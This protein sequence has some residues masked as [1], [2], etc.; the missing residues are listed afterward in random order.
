METSFQQPEENNPHFIVKR[1]VESTGELVIKEEMIDEIKDDYNHE[2]FKEEMV[3]EIK[4][5]NKYELF[6]EEM[7]D[8]IK[9]ESKYELFFDKMQTVDDQKYETLVQQGQAVI[10]KETSDIIPEMKHF[11]T[12]NSG[13]PLYKCDVCTGEIHDE[14]T[15][16]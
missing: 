11:E 9:D 5:E 1:E 12:A 10:K 3:D 4:Y 16:K 8:E 14:N 15:F 13:V 2:L 6:K 7:I